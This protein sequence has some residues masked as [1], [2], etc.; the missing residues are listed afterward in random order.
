MD[1]NLE[2]SASEQSYLM[3]STP[4]FLGPFLVIHFI[5]LSNASGSGRTYGSISAMVTVTKCRSAR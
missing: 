1:R 4:Y 3:P 5:V 2:A